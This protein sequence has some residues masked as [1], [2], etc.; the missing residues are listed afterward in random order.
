MG[1]EWGKGLGLEGK[2]REGRQSH[3]RHTIIDTKPHDARADIFGE[4]VPIC[5][6]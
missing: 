1:G 2:G 3:S 4:P 5:E 6:R